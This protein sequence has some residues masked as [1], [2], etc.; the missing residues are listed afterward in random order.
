[1]TDQEPQQQQDEKHEFTP[2]EMLAYIEEAPMPCEGEGI[3]ERDQTMDGYEMCA[4][5][6]ARAMLIVVREQR[7]QGIDLLDLSAERESDPSGWEA[8]N[9]DKLW[10]ATQ[11]R[12]PGLS[13]WLG[14]PT[15]FQ[16]GWAHNAVRYALGAEPTGNP[17][18]V[19]VGGGDGEA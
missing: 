5:S 10:A 9:N 2:D 13:E 18:I 4:K 12:F 11:E 7:E 1:M 16:F 8:A 17:A 6:L 14:G 3:Y 15:G 19:T